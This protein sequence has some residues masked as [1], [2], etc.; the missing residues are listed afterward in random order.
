VIPRDFITEWREHAPWV[1]DAQVEQ[2]LLGTKLR[3]L[4]QRKKGRDLFDLWYAIEKGAD[5]A[6]IVACFARDMRES[7]VDV[8]RAEFEQPGAP[9][10][11]PAL[12]VT[13]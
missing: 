3:A 11:R 1:T 6:E 2:E 8:T 5:P 13:V 7:A 4:Y 9:W 12:D 10:K